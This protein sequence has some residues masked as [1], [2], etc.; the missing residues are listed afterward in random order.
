MN[1]HLAGHLEMTFEFHDWDSPSLSL[2]LTE[3]SGVRDPDWDCDTGVS[4]L[5]LPAIPPYLT[6]TPWAE[7]KKHSC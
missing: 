1:A 3:S 5:I 4:H 6:P 2:S 7:K